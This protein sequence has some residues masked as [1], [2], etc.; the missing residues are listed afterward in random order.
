M[1]SLSAHGLAVAPPSGWDAQI[2]TPPPEPGLNLPLGRS[3]PTPPILHVANFGLPPERGDFGSGAVEV[4]GSGAVFVALLEHP[5]AEAAT[6]LF[7]STVVPWPLSADDFSPNSLQRA[8]SGQSGLQR[9]FVANGRP[10]CLYV[11]IGS[12]RQRA[13]LVREANRALAAVTID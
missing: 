8:N 11:V 2:Y 4:M 5:A 3:Q 1:P 7:A 10:F 12:H 6:A 9:F 13:V